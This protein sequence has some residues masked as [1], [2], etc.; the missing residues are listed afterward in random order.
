M[1][2]NSDFVAKVVTL[3]DKG[4]II[5][6][7]YAIREGVI[8]TAYHVIPDIKNYPKTYLRW[9]GMDDKKS[10]TDILYQ[11]K[12][13]DVL[14]AKCETPPNVPSIVISQNRPLST[15]SW[16]SFGY[17]KSAI[18]AIEKEREQETAGG[19]YFDTPKKSI[20]QQLASKADTTNNDFWKGMS[21]APIFTVG[22]NHL[23]AIFIETSL[24]YETK[25]GDLVPIF[26]GRLRAL[27][28]AKL[29][30]DDIGFSKYLCGGKLCDT[31]PNKFSL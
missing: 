1:S 16:T 12:K 29:L 4:F 27:S 20:I 14:I 6:T 23:T 18:D 11:S 21:G 8:I 30:E 22:T 13:Y 3:K 7:A 10:I 25:D 15:E 19:T 28:I 9:E 24:E 17:A 2:L 5:G 26:D 31:N